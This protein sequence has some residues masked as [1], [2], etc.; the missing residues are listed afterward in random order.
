MHRLIPH[1]L[2]NY[3]A[4]NIIFRSSNIILSAPKYLDGHFS[5]TGAADPTLLDVA[6]FRGEAGRRKFIP[7]PSFFTLA[8]ACAF[9]ASD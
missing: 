7:V 1:S 6:L 9:F 4:Q 3:Y 8:G 2:E 5:A